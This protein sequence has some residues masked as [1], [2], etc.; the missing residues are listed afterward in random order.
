M[1]RVRIRSISWQSG[2]RRGAN[3]ERQR[4]RRGARI[5]KILIRVGARDQR[6][7]A[8]VIAIVSVS[9]IVSWW[10]ATVRM[11]AERICVIGRNAAQRKRYF[12]PIKLL[13]QT[14]ATY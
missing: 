3:G 6:H 5:A 13:S 8:A 11:S 9:T 14:F 2:Q 12:K 4:L 1:H 10:S 7:L